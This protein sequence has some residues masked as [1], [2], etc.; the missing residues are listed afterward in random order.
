MS[1][2]IRLAIS[3]VLALIG[4]VIFVLSPIHLGLSSTPR[5]AVNG[6]L[7]GLLVGFAYAI[8]RD[9]FKS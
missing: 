7:G 5:S 9:R 1:S 2:Q 4:L 8:S 6:A 3:I